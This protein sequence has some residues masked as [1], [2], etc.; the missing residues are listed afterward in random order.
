[1]PIRE[2]VIEALT[3]DVLKRRGLTVHFSHGDPVVRQDDIVTSSDEYFAAR[4]QAEETYRL[5]I[6]QI[7]WARLV[8]EATGAW[9]ALQD[10]PDTH[11]PGEFGESPSLTGRALKLALLTQRTWPDWRDEL[12]ALRRGDD[13]A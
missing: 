11:D 6:D 12:A 5:V 9:L 2:R 10:D 1:M 13:G 8:I 7:D 4:R 3:K